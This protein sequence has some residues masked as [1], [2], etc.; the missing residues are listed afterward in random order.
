MESGQPAGSGAGESFRAA[1]EQYRL[2]MEHVTDYAIFFLDPLGRVSGWNAGAERLLGYAEAE[3][4]GRPFALFFTPEEHEQAE[5]ELRIAEQQGRADDECWLVRKDG[6]RFWANGVTTALRDE[7]KVLRGFAKVAR[8]GTDRK[9][10]QEGLAASERRFRALVENAFDGVTLIAADGTVLETTP[11]TFRGLG[12]APE[13][14]VGHNGLEL[15]HPEDAPTVRALLG[16]LLHQP[17]EKTTAQYRLR[18]KDGSYRW[19]EAVGTNLLADPAVKA[20]VVNHRDITLQRRAEEAL[21][22]ADRRKDEFLATL[23]HELRNPLAP[24][25]NAVE[26]LRLVGPGDE[27]LEMARNVIERQTAHLTRLVDDL[28]DVG[29]VTTG[30]VQLR[31]EILDAAAVMARAIETARPLVEARRHQLTVSV[32]DRPLPLEGDPVRLAQVLGNLLSN[33][34]KY[35][36]E[37]GRIELSARA[38]GET[39]VFRVRDEGLG[40]PPDMLTRIFELFTQVERN[41]DRA[42]GGLGI[43]L[44]LVKRLVELHGGTVEAHSEGPGKG[45]E[46]VVRLPLLPMGNGEWE[47]GNDQQAPSGIPHSPFPI[48]HSRRVLVVDDNADT[49]ESLALLLR[50]LGHEVRTAHDGPSA[51]K[52]A[53]REHPDVVLLDLG[54]PRLDGFEVARRLRWEYADR[55]LLL[56]ALTGHGQEEDR[57]RCREAGFDHH[58]VKPAEPETLKHLLAGR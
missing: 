30:K 48:P 20:V 21:K 42:H 55:P 11:I 52:V 28:L 12:Y 40:V 57:R 9:L 49:A 36:E 14:Y 10:A 46:F 8:D 5:Q 13:E 23:A 15:L 44:A 26:L 34:A 53:R 41:L 33:A 54:L 35:M 31:R 22:E 43:G 39:V 4:L 56:V 27:A 38:E 19:V 50:V 25:R 45:S 58:L 3:V 51:L 37:G 17:G 16:K 24:I 1:E 18:H 2:L 6:S 47:M 7:G 29:R 32:P